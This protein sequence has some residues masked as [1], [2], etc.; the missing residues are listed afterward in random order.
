M[1]FLTDEGSAGPYG[2]VPELQGCLDWHGPVVGAGRRSGLAHM[3]GLL[4]GRHGARH[5]LHHLRHQHG[6]FRLLRPHQT[7]KP[8]RH[9]GHFSL[10]LNVKGWFNILGNKCIAFDSVLTR[11]D[12]INKSKYRYSSWLHLNVYSLIMLMFLFL[13]HRI[14]YTLTLKTDSSCATSIRGPA[15][16]TSM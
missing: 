3:V 15:R 2:R 14:M 6:S 16:R 11:K 7:G 9:A 12:K 5:V 10:R 1:I 4:L 8:Q 13:S